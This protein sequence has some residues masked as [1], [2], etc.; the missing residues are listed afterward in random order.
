MGSGSRR[1]R[2]SS[3][4]GSHGSEESFTRYHPGQLGNFSTSIASP[5]SGRT[6]GGPAGS[7][8]VM[9]SRVPGAGQ[10]EL[11]RVQARFPLSRP[12]RSHRS[13]GASS[14]SNSDGQGYREVS[15]RSPPP[16]TSSRKAQKSPG[17]GRMAADPFDMSVTSNAAK[18]VRHV[19]SYNLPPHTSCFLLSSSKLFFFK[20]FLLLFFPVTLGHT[21]LSTPRS[22]RSLVARS[23]DDG[24][25]GDR[26]R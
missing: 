26:F 5:T 1:H 23:L 17:W 19:P 14:A 22:G 8:D 13:S 11:H 25:L 12:A 10:A 2:A 16:Q 20:F 3:S 24:N 15:I 7:W 4:G 9:R 21:F 18:E 6:Q